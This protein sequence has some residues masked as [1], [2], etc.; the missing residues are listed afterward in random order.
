MN[1]PIFYRT[2]AY[3]TPDI[4]KGGYT[5]IKELGRT[6]NYMAARIDM[7]ISIRIWRCPSTKQPF[8]TFSWLAVSLFEFLPYASMPC[9]SSAIILLRYATEF[10]G[11]AFAYK[12]SICSS[13]RPLVYGMKSGAATIRRQQWNASDWAGTRRTSGIQ[14]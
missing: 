2:A 8:Y 10:M 11:D 3:F 6:N 7:N 1:N 5:L 12:M 13:A 14:K 4:A 9:K